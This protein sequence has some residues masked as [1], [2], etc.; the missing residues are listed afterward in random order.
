MV[1]EELDYIECRKMLERAS[2]ARLAC[3]VDN[4]PYIVPIHVD[5]GDGSLYGYS[6]L[7][8]KINWMRVNPL[9]CLEFEE[10]TSHRQWATLIVSG[11][12]EELPDT[13]ENAYARNVAERLF[14]RHPVWWE[15]ASVP[16]AGRPPRE[17]ILFRIVISHMSGRRAAPEPPDRPTLVKMSNERRGRWLTRVVRRISRKK[18]S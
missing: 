13:S 8:Q 14:Q 5:F 11:E 3:A 1:I 2:L 17:R 16:L 12:Y 15:P 9:V 6:T 10:L 7:G 18:P 4:Q